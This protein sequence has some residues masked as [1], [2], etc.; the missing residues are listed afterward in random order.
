MTQHRQNTI[1]NLW[2]ACLYNKILNIVTFM[3]LSIE[4]LS[5]A[6]IIGSFDVGFIIFSHKD[7]I[8]ILDQHAA[9]ERVRLDN[10]IKLYKNPLLIKERPKHIL[11]GISQMDLNLLKEIQ[12]E[13]SLINIL[14]ALKSRAC[15]GAIT[16]RDEIDDQEDLLKLL[17]QSRF[18]FI[19]A[20]G[21]P[22]VA[23]ITIPVCSEDP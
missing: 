14:P 7:N 13:H 9:H 16:I 4:S 12:N 2:V 19:C 23:L 15:R 11:L 18:P 3:S 10:L 8:Y 21:R 20:H 6:I 5:D 1:K 22:T 17:S